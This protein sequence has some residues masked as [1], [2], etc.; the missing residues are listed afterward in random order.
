MKG[1]QTSVF[2]MLAILPGLAQAQDTS[3]AATQLDDIVV[4]AN[5]EETEASKVGSTVIVKTAEDIRASGETSLANYFR[6][7]SGLTVDT[8]GTIGTQATVLLRGASQNYIAATFDGIDITDPSSTQVSLDFGQM[9]TGDLGRIEVLKGSQSALYGAGAVGGVIA[10]TSR[11]PEQDGLHHFVEAEVGS[12]NS[13]SASY[14][15]TY[16]DAATE[17]AVTLGRV[18]TDGFS[19]AADGTEADGF[20]SSRLSFSLAHRLDNGLRLG[21]NGFVEDSASDYDPAFFLP[22]S[23]DGTRLSY[24]DIEANQ[25]ALGDGATSDEVLSRETRGLRGFAEFSTGAVDH[26]VGLSAY[27][28]RRAYHESEVNAD[29]DDYDVGSDTYGVT[30]ITTDAAYTG[31]RVKADWMAGLDAFGGRLVL[32]ADVTRET[33]DQTGDYGAAD[34]AKS[35]SGLVSEFNGEIGTQTDVTLSARLDHD[36]IFGESPTAR[37]ALAHHLGDA[38]TL[39]LQAGTGFRAPSNFELFSDYGSTE[40]QPEKS[41]NLD[42]GIEQ[43]LGDTTVLR[44]TAFWL[45]VD[46]L[47]DWDKNSTICPASALWG[48]GCYD[49]IEG[50]SMRRGLELEAQT[51]LANGVELAG[52][53]TYTDSDTNASTA[54]AQVPAHKLALDLGAPLAEGLT[55]RLGLVAAFDRPN[56]TDGTAAPNYALLNG[57]LS[58]DLGNQ[59]EA[60]LRVE[61][62]TDEDY[63]LS[64]DY[65]TSGRAFYVGL[66]TSF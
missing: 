20:S 11:R 29:W 8:R 48:P 27:S 28:I 1:L 39:R 26:T 25:V 10:M 3:A 38:T 32:G 31:Q 54:W 19:N 18:Q 6:R 57:S 13:A 21:L 2:A 52:N 50:T 45:A 62:L 5:L 65:G 33:L 41:R 16:R 64:Q 58:Y 60:Y 24:D 37:V 40:L 47:I 51:V 17:A 34:N 46:N 35:K 12:F 63:E 30:T 66:R 49:Q 53:Y 59:R 55:G 56:W 7:L 15:M 43:E 4:S 36:S 42:L 9:T 23:Y 44:A 61:N 14:G 22:A